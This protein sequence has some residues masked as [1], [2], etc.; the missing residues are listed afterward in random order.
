MAS[1]RWKRFAFFER[2]TLSLPSEVLEDLIP[3]GGADGRSNRRSL[4]ALR[5][6]N[7]AN[8][9][10]VS[11]V[12]TTAALPLNS[13]PTQSLVEKDAELTALSS[14]WSSLN[15]CAAMEL[16][17]LGEEAIMRLPNQ[18]NFT[19]TESNLPSTDTAA[20]GLVLIFVT[21]QDTDL[22]HCFDVTVRCNPSDSS[23]KDLED[24]DGW[25][26]YFAPFKGQHVKPPQSSLSS[27][28]V[29]DRII[30]EHMEP[31]MAEGVVGVATCRETSGNL[32]VHMACISE[33]NVVVIKDPHLY[34]SW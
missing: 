6:S 16:P 24:L 15:A 4:S 8:Y 18:A 5:D 11:L 12:V 20:D 30:S 31:E 9:D 1:S 17:G 34:L 19:E 28:N 22:V 29:E 21:S 10:S 23:E 14:M 26:G 3:I 7:E 25:R 32:Q 33:K 27:R 2:H 13:K